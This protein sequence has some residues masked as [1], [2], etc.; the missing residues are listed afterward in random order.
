MHLA[1]EKL[2][3]LSFST[4]VYIKMTASRSIHFT[5]KGIR[6][7]QLRLKFT[8]KGQ[9]MH[10]ETLQVTLMSAYTFILNV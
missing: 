3:L 10:F 4:Y 2:C 5:N 9:I 7:T 1:G 8:R 6:L